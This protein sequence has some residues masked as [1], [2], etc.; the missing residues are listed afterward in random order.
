MRSSHQPAEATLSRLQIVAMLLHPFLQSSKGTIVN[1]RAV[2]GHV[3]SK[4]QGLLHLLTVLGLWPLELWSQVPAQ[5][6]DFS[7]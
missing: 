1:H 6:F 3:L 2:F 7:N 4:S 5:A